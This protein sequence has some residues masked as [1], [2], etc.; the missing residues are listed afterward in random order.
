MEKSDTGKFI[1]LRQIPGR[2]LKRRKTGKIDIVA[3]ERENWDTYSSITK[4]EHAA[5]DHHAI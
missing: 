1:I 5:S 2:L 4:K 3:S